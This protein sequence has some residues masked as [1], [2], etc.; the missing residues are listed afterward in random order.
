MEWRA[1]SIAI[2]RTGA[3]AVILLISAGQAPAQTPPVPDA[4]SQTIRDIQSIDRYAFPVG[5][6]RNGSNPSKILTGQVVRTAFRLGGDDGSVEQMLAF[7]RDWAETSGKLVELDCTREDCGGFDFRFGIELLSPPAMR[8]DVRDFGQISLVDP[9]TR[10]HHSIL[11]SRV[12]GS[13]Y[14]QIVSVAPISG[15]IVDERERLDRPVPALATRTNEHEPTVDPLP[16]S[17]LARLRTDGRATVEGL[18]FSAGGARLTGTSGDAISKVAAM[19]KENP[20]V[21]VAIVGHSDNVGSLDANIALSERRAAAVL[22]ALVNRGVTQSRLE[23][24]GIGYL[25]PL[26]SNNTAKG[27]AANRR[28]EL[29]ILD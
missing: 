17:L 15:G 24:K 13:V 20:T 2:I 14:L 19:L 8:M 9:E 27:R 28:V 4:A 21:D 29:V 25:A 5:V 23:A 11:A 3:M 26:Q 16:L 1:P 6:F 7:Y 18:T 10:A 22:S 12:L